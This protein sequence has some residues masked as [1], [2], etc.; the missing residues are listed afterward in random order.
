MSVLFTRISLIRSGRCVVHDR[1]H[2]YLLNKLLHKSFLKLGFPRIRTST[3]KNMSASGL[4]GRRI[5][6]PPSRV[7]EKLITEGKVGYR[8]HYY[9]DPFYQETL[10]DDVEQRI[11]LRYLFIDQFQSVIGLGQHFWI[12]TK[13]HACLYLEVIGSVWT[14]VVDTND[15]RWGSHIIYFKFILE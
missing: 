15:S 14:G 8:V 1:H 9:A 7:V 12:E 6:N 11:E 2:A 3:Y 13:S 10:W 4:L 5:Q